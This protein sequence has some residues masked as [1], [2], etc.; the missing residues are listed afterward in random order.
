MRKLLFVAFVLVLSEGSMVFAQDDFNKFELYGGY[1]HSRVDRGS[2]ADDFDEIGD[3][4]NFFENRQGFHGFEAAVVGNVSR[5]VG[6]KFDFSAQWN[7]DEGILI[8]AAPGRVRSS[9]FNILGG[10]QFKDNS[11]DNTSAVRPFAHALIGAAVARNEFAALDDLPGVD[12]DVDETGFAAAIGGGLDFRL[13]DSV[14]LRAFQVDWNP[15]R[16]NGETRHNFR[17]GI[18]LVLH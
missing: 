2:G 10:F 11:T 17:F 12:D 6:G 7:N 8:D 15:M 9:L 5:Y 18:G 13:N 1:S 3:I 16:F 14:D 4:D